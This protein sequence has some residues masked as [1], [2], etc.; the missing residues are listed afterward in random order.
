MKFEIIPAKYYYEDVTGEYTYSYAGKDWH[1]DW[2][3]HSYVMESEL[4]HGDGAYK[5]F[6][7]EK[8][9]IEWLESVRKSRE[10]YG[11]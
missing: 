6:S 1:A 2:S 8:E 7:T 4:Q 3:Q 10:G 5:I 9:C 11:Y